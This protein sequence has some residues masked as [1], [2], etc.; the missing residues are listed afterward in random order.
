MK[1]YGYVFPTPND[2]ANDTKPLY[3]A[4][5]V[6]FQNPSLTDGYTPRSKD[7]FIMIS[8]GYDGIFGTSDDIVYGN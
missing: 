3:T 2:F 7:S 8:A 1:P 6:F 5:Q 4:P